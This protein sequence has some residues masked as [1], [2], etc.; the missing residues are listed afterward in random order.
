M[1]HVTNRTFRTGAKPYKVVN[2]VLPE[3]LPITLEELKSW[4]KIFNSREDDKL[5]SIIKGVT[6]EAERYTHRTFIIKEFET[7]RDIFGDVD[8]SPAP[9]YPHKSNP[10]VLRRSPF[11]DIESI[12]YVK[13][14]VEQSI[15]LIQIAEKNCY[16][17]IFPD[18]NESWPSFDEGVVYPITV[19]FTAGYATDSTGMPEDLKIALLTHATFIYKNPG[20][21]NNGSCSCAYAP[22]TAKAVYDQY[23]ILEFRAF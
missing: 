4:A 10:I 3:E 13:D 19:N 16:S 15:P 17:Q 6:L 1:V 12:T 22:A 8:E 7:K 23:R 9:G 18:V 14:G 2:Q 20:D 5:I 11:V 21:C